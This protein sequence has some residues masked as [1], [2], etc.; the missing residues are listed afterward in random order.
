MAAKEPSLEAAVRADAGH[1]VATRTISE[2]PFV[3]VRAFTRRH[4]RRRILLLAPHS[5]LAASALSP[6]VA[7]LLTLGEVWITDWRD[8]RLVPASAGGFDLARQAD[9]AAALLAADDRPAHLV[10][11]SQS[12]PALLIA[13]ATSLMR[14]ASMALLGSPMDAR[15]SPTPFQRLFGQWPRFAAMA[16]LTGLVPYGHPG[17]GRPVYPGLLQLLALGIVSPDTYFGVQHGLLCDLLDGEDRGFRRQ[18][19]DLHSV[20]DVPAELFAD[21]LDWAVYRPA[22]ESGTAWLGGRPVPL[23]P[24]SRIPLLTVEAAADELIGP[25]QTH[26]TAEA[27]G[28]G[29]RHVALDLSHARH[30]DLFTGPIFVRSLAPALFRFIAQAEP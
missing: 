7:A 18:H 26:A 11:F 12:G 4:T 17:A 13:A 20:I 22:L 3:H 5:G 30:P 6:L 21:M 2:T 8:A 10:A 24:L 15:R 25:G 14:P 19:T 23:A 29:V 28:N 9:L 16:Q 27:I 1:G